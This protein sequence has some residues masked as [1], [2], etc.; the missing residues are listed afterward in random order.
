GTLYGA[1]AL[2]SA[3]L[4][5][6]ELHDVIAELAED[7]YYFPT[8]PLTDPYSSAQEQTQCDYLWQKYPGY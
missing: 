6:L 1:Q 8:W 4:E 5:P 2:P 3:W 7:L